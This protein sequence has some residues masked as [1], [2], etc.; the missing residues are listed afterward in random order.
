MK[1]V[2]R[3]SGSNATMSIRNKRHVKDA[4]PAFFE[5]LGLASVA[6]SSPISP[7]LLLRTATSPSGRVRPHKS[8]S[9]QKSA[10]VGAL[11]ISENSVVPLR[12]KRAG[13]LVVFIGYYVYIV[14]IIGNDLTARGNKC[15][16]NP[17][18]ASRNAF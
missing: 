3:N 9:G 5:A 12:R 18:L 13:T 7:C 14:N 2:G 16:D 10:R 6:V 15:R 1:A 4:Y 17:I 8:D 11:A